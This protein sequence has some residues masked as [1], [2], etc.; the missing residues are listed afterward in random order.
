MFDF[1]DET[2]HF[3][4][5]WSTRKNKVVPSRDVFRPVDTSFLN[6]LGDLPF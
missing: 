3:F 1:N 4:K 6:Q 2:M 5:N